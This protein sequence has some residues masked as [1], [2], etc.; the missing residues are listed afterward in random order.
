MTSCNVAAVQLDDI[1]LKIVRTL[2][3]DGRTSY[4]DISKA[5]GVSA[6]TVR[7][8]INQMRASG[9]LSVNVWLDPS[10]SGLG[11]HATL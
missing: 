6:G 8:R 2:Q 9:M 10:L 7:N 1:D 11:I 5:V 3:Q 4:S